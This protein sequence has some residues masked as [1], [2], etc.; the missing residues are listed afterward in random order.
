[1]YGLIGR[2]TSKPGERDALLALMLQGAENLPGC[3]SYIVARDTGDE[4]TV[5]ITEVWED[6][7]SH[8]AS[9]QLSSVRDA[10]AKAVPLI[11][12]MEPGVVTNPVGGVGL[13]SGKD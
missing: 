7:A 1:M 12:G 3:L 4:N 9:L 5:W 6:E 8:Q 10:I 11:A 13:P 2:M